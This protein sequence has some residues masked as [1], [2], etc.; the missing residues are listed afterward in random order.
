[1]NDLYLYVGIEHSG[2]ILLVRQ[3]TINIWLVKEKRSIYHCM[4]M[5]VICCISITHDHVVDYDENNQNNPINFSL[6]FFL[7]YLVKIKMLLEVDWD[8]A[9]F[10][11]ILS[12]P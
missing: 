1:M 8:P 10:F 5:T 7:M 3:K 2:A 6:N 9:D 11:K 12:C 4:H